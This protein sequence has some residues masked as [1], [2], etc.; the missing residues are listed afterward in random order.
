MIFDSMIADSSAAVGWSFLAARGVVRRPRCCN[1]RGAQA[2][3]GTV[4]RSTRETLENDMLEGERARGGVEAQGE[5][6]A[7][8][9]M[10]EVQTG[11]KGTRRGR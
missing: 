11:R 3:A 4:R 8:R 1:G 2:A 7:L 6:G 5:Q 10:I 9:V